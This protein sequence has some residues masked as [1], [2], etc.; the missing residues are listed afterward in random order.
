MDKLI[1]NLDIKEEVYRNRFTSTQWGPDITYYE[2]Y[3][4]NRLPFE[5]CEFFI[6]AGHTDRDFD[7][8][9]EAFRG[10]PYKLKI[11]CTPDSIPLSKEIPS[12][13]ELNWEITFSKDLIPFYQKS[14]AIL[15]PLKYPAEK[16][17]CQ[18]M[19]SLQDVLTFGKPTIITKNPCLN[20]D[21]E[22]EGLGYMVNMHD[23]TGWKEK[24]EILATNPEVWENMSR[25]SAQVFKSKVNSV[26]FADHLGEVLTS[27]YNKCNLESKIQHA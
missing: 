10:L 15:I 6:S 19:T 25:S 1:A 14:I 27:V 8:L 2:K 9:I 21:V 4:L 11:F 13:V 5:Q 18:G 16:E 12:N 20:I 7:L 26:I 24:V 23:V 17:G 3:C 22:K